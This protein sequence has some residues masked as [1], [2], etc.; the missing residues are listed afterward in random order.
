MSITEPNATDLKPCPFC[1]GQAYYT[2][3]VNGSQMHYVGCS[4]CGFEFKAQE[5]HHAD[6]SLDC[7]TRDIVA[8]WNQRAGFIK[9]PEA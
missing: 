1:G 7:L 3:S 5:V 9:E 4:T 6:T 2:R 8:A